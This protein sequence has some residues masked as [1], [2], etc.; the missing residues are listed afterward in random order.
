MALSISIETEQ[1][2]FKVAFLFTWINNLWNYD[3]QTSETMLKNQN[4]HVEIKND[5]ISQNTIRGG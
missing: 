1:N 3:A 2:N 5:Y 4:K